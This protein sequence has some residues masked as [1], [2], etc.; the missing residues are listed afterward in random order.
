MS[1]G[2]LNMAR[3]CSRLLIQTVFTSQSS[4][5]SQGSEP[6]RIDDNNL[7]AG[8]TSTEEVD[9]ATRP[10]TGKRTSMATRR[11]SSA[12]HGGS[13]TR[14][15]NSLRRGRSVSISSNTSTNEA[16]DETNIC[17]MEV[18][19]EEA[20]SINTK[21][22]SESSVPPKQPDSKVM[23]RLPLTRSV[24]SRLPSNMIFSM[25]YSC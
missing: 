5:L 12:S 22:N 4:T 16:E 6:A 19:G 20:G 18:V 9:A 24:I 11:R 2:A 25:H 14:R 3:E 21:S 13:Q 1:Q 7:N 17:A 8:T 15:S 23:V 10:V